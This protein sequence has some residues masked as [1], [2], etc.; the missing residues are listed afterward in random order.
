MEKNKIKR[1]K[2]GRFLPGKRSKVVTKSKPK[3]VPEVKLEVYNSEKVR[4]TKKSNYSFEQILIIL[5]FLFC[6]AIAIAIF[7]VWVLW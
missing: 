3:N 4:K 5:G 2:N 7:A 1:D 6:V